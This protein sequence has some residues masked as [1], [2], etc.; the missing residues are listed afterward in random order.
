M[1]LEFSQD[2]LASVDKWKLNHG[3]FPSFLATLKLA[4]A[5][6]MTPA[7]SSLGHI[8]SP[9]V[10]IFLFLSS[11][12][13][14][15][16]HSCHLFSAFHCCHWPPGEHC[17]PTEGTVMGRPLATL[18]C[19]QGHLWSQEPPCTLTELRLP[20]LPWSS[21]CHSGDDGPAAPFPWGSATKCV[22][23]LT[24]LLK[25]LPHSSLGKANQSKAKQSLLQ[26]KSPK[27]CPLVL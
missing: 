9:C 16:C 10:L 20:W 8:H 27:C 21:R 24:C 13:T 6:F 14:G 11:P 12:P 18:G 7:N 15:I 3:T 25:P 19:T 23:V 2:S 1:F 26:R 5:I 22:S 17:H 4:L